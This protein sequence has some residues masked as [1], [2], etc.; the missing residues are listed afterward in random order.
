MR[1]ASFSNAG[2]LHVVLLSHVPP[3]LVLILFCIIFF[4]LGLFKM[5]VISLV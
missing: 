1:E 4:S 2:H 5:D 3:G